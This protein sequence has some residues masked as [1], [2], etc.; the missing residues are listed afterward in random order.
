M[1]LV[2]WCGSQDRTLEIEV[3]SDQTAVV[4]E[5]LKLSADEQCRP[6]EDLPQAMAAVR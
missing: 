4:F 6:Y 5:S 2:A 1:A 3:V